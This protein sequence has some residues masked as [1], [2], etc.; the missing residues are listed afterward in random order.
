MSSEGRISRLLSDALR[1]LTFRVRAEDVAR[2]GA[3]HL[4]F[5]LVCTWLVGMGRYWDNPRVGWAQH[6]GLGSVAY[7][8]ALA[9]LLWLVLLPLRPAE[10]SYPRLLTYVT[11]T[12]PPAALYA[13]PIERWLDLDAARSVNLG[14]LAAVALWRLAMYGVYVRRVA[15][16][17]ALGV[18]V[19]TFLPVVAIVWTLTLLNL[20]RAV[21]EVMAGIRAERTAAD[22]AYVALI[23][24][25]V[26]AF[27]ALPVLA[28][29]YLVEC[30]RVR[31]RAPGAKLGGHGGEP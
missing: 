24:L 5:G 11:L 20:E 13:I 12:A 15:R 10:R 29:L 7:V 19:A 22:E 4:A 17:G 8:F 26:L 3:A 28:L 2:F 25:S 18:V 27:Y 6:L 9:G 23:A 16:L 14:F 21:F 1:V 30:W 31:R